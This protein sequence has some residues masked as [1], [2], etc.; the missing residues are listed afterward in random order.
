L[1]NKKTHMVKVLYRILKSKKKHG[2][3]NQ[4]WKRNI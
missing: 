4:R 1:I 3:E 2:K